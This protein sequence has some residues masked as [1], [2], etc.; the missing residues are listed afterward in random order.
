MSE[1]LVALD[2]PE[3]ARLY[4]LEQTIERGRQTFVEVGNALVEIR[5]G[6]LYRESHGTFEDYCLDRWQFSKTQANRL[7]QASEVAEALAPM[8][9]IPANERQAR[10]LAPLL[11]EPEQLR[12]AWAEASEDGKPTAAKVEQAVAK[13]LDPTS[14]TTPDQDAKFVRDLEGVEQGSNWDKAV[15]RIRSLVRGFRKFGAADLVATWNDEERAVFARQ[16]D[17]AI[18]ELNAIRNETEEVIARVA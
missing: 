13:R 3:A 1:T 7:V 17:L 2:G 14:L 11:D 10:E 15:A 9:V 18:N 12:E 16:L 4:R 8:G 6:R 5:N